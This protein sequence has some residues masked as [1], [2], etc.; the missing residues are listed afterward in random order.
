MT[1]MNVR[2]KIKLI[3]TIAAM[4]LVSAVSF[5]ATDEEVAK[6]MTTLYRSARGVITESISKMKTNPKA[7]GLNMK[8][9]KKR[10]EKL[11]LAS[12]G[13]KLTVDD[14]PSKK[15]MEAIDAVFTKAF[16]DGYADTWAT[17]EHYPNKLLPARFAREVGE[18]LKKVSAGKYYIRLTVAPDCLV[19]SSNAPDT[20]EK[21]TIV[22]K[23]SQKSWKRNEGFSETV[24]DS[25]RYILPEYY[26]KG[27]LNCHGGAPGKAIHPKCSG[28]E[29]GAFGGAISISIKK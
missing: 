4:T 20:W 10:V 15:L 16:A 9:A 23:L 12:T 22:K 2:L 3:I 17:A 18:E 14:E 19:N 11:Y 6:K 25:F 26:A 24:G 1:T 7:A 28:T 13:T 21:D 29:L 5:G 8:K 27:C